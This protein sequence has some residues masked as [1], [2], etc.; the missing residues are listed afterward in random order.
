MHFLKEILFCCL[1]LIIS[2]TALQAQ[3][4]EDKIRQ[5]LIEAGY[6][7]A[8]VETMSSDELREQ[9]KISETVIN[10]D[11]IESNGTAEPQNDE[12]IIPDVESPKPDVIIPEEATGNPDEVVVNDQAKIFGHQYFRNNSI[13]LF[14]QSKNIRPSGQYVIG[15]GDE[16]VVS[17]WNRVDFDG[18]YVVSDDGHISPEG[19]PR[20]YVKGFTYDK[21]KEIIRSRFAQRFD[22]KKGNIDVA[23]NFA[24]NITVNIVGEV[25][26]PGA[27]TIPATNTG[28]NALVAAG[29][30]TDIGTVRNI[31]LK[32]VGQEDKILD[33]YQ[34]ILNPVSENK[35]YLEDGDY[36]YVSSSGRVVEVKGAVKRP[37]KYELN[38]TEHLFDLLNYAGG[39]EPD[40]NKNNVKIIRYVNNERIIKDLNLGE[41]KRQNRDFKLLDG[42]VV[43]LNTVKTEVVNSVYV[44]GA[45]LQPGNYEIT[46]STRILQIIEKAGLD[47]SARTD[48]IY[49]TRET[50]S[51]LQE[52]IPIDLNA[53]KRNSGNRELNVEL[54]PNDKIYVYSIKRFNTNY[55]ISISGAVREP[56]DYVYSKGFTLND[57]VFLS[58]GLLDNSSGSKIEIYRIQFDESG[59]QTKVVEATVD[60]SKDLRISEDINLKP[61]DK[62]YVRSAPGFSLQ[63][64]IFIEGEVS[65]PGVYSILQPGERVSDVLERAGG[66]KESAFPEGA[67]LF[68]KD[69]NLGFVL[70]DLNEV[71]AN[72][73]SYFNYTLKEGDRIVI[74]RRQELVTIS[75]AINFPGIDTFQNISVPYFKGQTAEYYVEKFAGGV[76]R[77]KRGRKKRIYVRD[78]NGGVSRTRGFGVF[79]KYPKVR[80]GSTIIVGT[81]PI[82]EKTR[83]PN[84]KRVDWGDVAK[85]TIAIATSVLTLYLL[86]DRTTSN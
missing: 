6:D 63:E 70:L 78:P 37:Y 40:V 2:S 50:D 77:E 47:I 64:N 19:L 51:G 30:P 35:F 17:I 69:G 65:I 54:K 38:R 68:R 43:V 62:I 42:D 22:L 52:R 27:Y 13:R 11:N 28:F 48:R 80:A 41:L 59:A 12:I 55:N 26:Q 31:R 74:P 72:T 66:L 85:D 81:K 44:D 76:D 73:E 20:I 36:L 57:I 21:V 33:V 25:F 7:P 75:G 82:K 84:R 45:V 49:V 10:Q 58:G 8:V 1:I 24:R 60:I 29:G 71:F 32:R 5:T 9:L 18:V 3:S 86:I 67:R 56:G 46:S 16:L 15:A 39:V 4:T 79:K 83:D 14:E 61:F 34:Y 23:L 53:A